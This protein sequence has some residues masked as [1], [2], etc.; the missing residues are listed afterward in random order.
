M[1]RIS[2]NVA[3][4]ITSNRT[5]VTNQFVN[6]AEEKN[7]ALEDAETALRGEISV[8]LVRLIKSVRNR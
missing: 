8:E 7:N 1:R 6:T 4:R 2:N 3:R 5:S